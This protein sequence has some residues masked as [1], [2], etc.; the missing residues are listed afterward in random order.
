MVRFRVAAHTKANRTQDIS[1]FLFSLDG[2]TIAKCLTYFFPRD[3]IIHLFP[4]IFC[5]VFLEE[6]MYEVGTNEWIK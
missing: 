1:Y 5:V 4:F 3:S 2:D 6:S